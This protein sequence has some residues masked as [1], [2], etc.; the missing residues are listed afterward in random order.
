MK[1][2]YID[3]NAWNYLFDRN[4]DLSA[5]FPKDSFSIFITREVE[6]ELSAIQDMGKDGTDKRALKAYIE[7]SL[8]ANRVQTS[9]V[10][11]FA[12]IEPDGSLSKVQVYG[13]FGQ[14][15]FQSV[16]DRDWHASSEVKRFTAAK[17]KR[18]SGLS[19]NQADAS[20]GAR[21]FDSIVLTREPA[22]G[23]GPLQLAAQQGG[24]VLF[25]EEVERSGLS[26]ADYIAANF[27]VLCASTPT[28]LP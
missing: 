13:G 7:G 23:K 25:L 11:G 24:Q 21:S 27:P 18:G 20:L 9:S 28:E 16:A 14:G 10:F 22:G 6:I 15:T 17:S 2:I 8:L 1:N 12:A 26:L 4:I 19:A 5:V 3:S